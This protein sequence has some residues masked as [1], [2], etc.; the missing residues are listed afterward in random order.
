M[1]QKENECKN[2]SANIE[3]ICST[4]LKVCLKEGLEPFKGCEETIKSIE[5]FSVLFD[6]LNSQNLKSYGWKSPMC[7]ENYVV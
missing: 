3:C 6:I 7:S 1:A 2:T 5:T 4:S